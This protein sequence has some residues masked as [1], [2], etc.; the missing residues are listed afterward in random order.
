MTDPIPLYRRQQ[1]LQPKPLHRNHRI[2]NLQLPVRNHR[3]PNHVR[4]RQHA[5]EHVVSLSGHLLIHRRH[6]RRRD[7]I[8]M[9]QNHAFARPHGSRRI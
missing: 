6:Q 9:T 7:E 3:Q 5:Q 1:L 2:P 4:H 8:P